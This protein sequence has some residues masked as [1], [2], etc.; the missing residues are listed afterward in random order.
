LV[1]EAGETLSLVL[2]G[3]PT[4]K[5]KLSRATREEGLKLEKLL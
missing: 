4:L 1:E 5:N 2:A 3:H